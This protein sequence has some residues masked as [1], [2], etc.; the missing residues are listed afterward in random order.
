MVSKHVVES[1]E[2]LGEDGGK[3]DGGGGRCVREGEFNEV[4]PGVLGGAVGGAADKLKVDKLKLAVA[5]MVHSE[6]W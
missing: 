3:R 1:A 2:M 5:L 6:R 4:G